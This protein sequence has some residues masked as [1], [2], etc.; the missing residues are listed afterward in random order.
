M[1]KA[2]KNALEL[3]D[4]KGANSTTFKTND[5]KIRKGTK[6][7]S[8]ISHLVAGNKLHRFQAERICHDHVLPSTIAGFQR[9]F[10]IMVARRMITVPAFEGMPTK[11]AQYWLVPEERAKAKQ[12][13]EAV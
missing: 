11:V 5:S 7:Y 13:L 10:G 9:S 4:S 3:R 1:T 8:V 6:L 2:I 12:L